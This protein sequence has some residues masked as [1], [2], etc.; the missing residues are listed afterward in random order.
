MKSCPKIQPSKPPK[1]PEEVQSIRD[2]CIFSIQT[3]QRQH[4]DR[5][6]VMKDPRNIIVLGGKSQGY[7]DKEQ[8]LLII[9]AL[10]EYWKNDCP[11]Q[12]PWIGLIGQYSHTSNGD[13]DDWDFTLVSPYP[14]ITE[15]A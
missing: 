6:L 2:R 4:S 11:P 7:C 15:S 1:S 12:Y 14:Q 5:N 10:S 9:P 13:P 8:R 3:V